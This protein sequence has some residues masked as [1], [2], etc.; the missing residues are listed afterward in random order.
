VT[1]ALFRIFGWILAASAPDPAYPPARVDDA[2]ET[3]HGVSV[4][5]PYRWMENLESEETKRWIGAEEELFRTFVEGVP[6]RE[7]F[8]R[9]ILQLSGRELFLAPVKAGGRY[10]LTKITSTGVPAGLWVQDGRHG[11]PRRLIDP[12]SRGEGT[13]LGGFAPSP[14]GRRVAYTVAE[15]QSRWL[16]IRIADAAT[17]EDLPV[18]PLQTHALAGSP[19]WTPDSRAFFFVR[20]EK[21][22]GSADTAPPDRPT[23]RRYDVEPRRESLAYEPPAEPGLLVSCNVSDDG[24]DLV[25]TLRDGSS[26][27]NRVGLMGV[28]RRGQPRFLMPAADAN[29][30]YLGSRGNRF[31]FF[32]DRDAPRG[33]VVRVERDHPEPARWK[34]IVPQ[35]AEP[36]AASSAVG[37]NAL[38]MFD[39]RILLVYLRDGRP[40]LRVF[41]SDGRFRAEPEL[42]P[43]G[44]IWGGFSGWPGDPEV[45][46]RF[47]GLT[48]ASTTYRLDLE[49]CQTSIF[50]AGEAQPGAGAVAIEQVFFTS[51][52]GTR[53]P[54]FL[55]HR[56]DF[57]RDGRAPAFMYGYGAFGWV[58]F[59]WYQP[60]VLNWLELGGVYALPGIR[61]GGE[62]GEDWHKAGAGRS[63]QK[64]IDDYL[65][66]AEWLVANRYT[67]RKLLVANGGSAS[68][69]VAAAAVL[70]R[71]ELFG[72]AV[73]DRPVLDMLRFDRFSQAAYW[74]AEFGSPSDRA[75][76]DALRSWSPYH[77]VRKG[78]C[79]PPIL[80]MAGERDQVAVPLHA[81][82]FTAALQ[83]AQGCANPALLQVVRGAGH[84]FGATP[85]QTAR[86][87]AD[88]TAFLVGVLRIRNTLGSGLDFSD[89]SSDVRR[90]APVSNPKNPRR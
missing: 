33:R 37:G 53:V 4:A 19:A 7:E 43:G 83:A 44:Q 70:Q 10:F 66:A 46:Y 85:E 38:G 2:V 14:D 11:A 8:Q 20:F 5:D 51:A 87:W 88:E 35:A 29:Y 52:D 78:T 15:G 90:A 12:K 57:R 56:K 23:V 86:T 47:L 24:L 32:T 58:S 42:P 50:S 61:G 63:K 74:M 27:K 3:R 28:E 84:N 54:M 62:Y 73:I 13:T 69:G 45:F 30:T 39:G 41:D 34:E 48:H 77:N 76:F 6:G 16:R 25:L 21:A 67:S 72:A 82:K 22:P 60:F 65:A 31:W 89:S 79:Y 55:A 17:G 9:R 64:A 59:L 26:S 1:G 68:G 36:V 18:P 71:P 75:D 80:V 81:Y 49:T 40:V